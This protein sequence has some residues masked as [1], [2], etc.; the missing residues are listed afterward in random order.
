MNNGIFFGSMGGALGD[1]VPRYVDMSDLN[2]IE[3]SYDWLSGLGAAS[4][5][6]SPGRCP[7]RHRLECV[8]LPPQRTGASQRCPPGTELVKNFNVEQC[9]PRCRTGSV[10]EPERIG[11]RRCVDRFSGRPTSGLGAIDSNTIWMAQAFLNEELSKRR[12]ATVPMDGTLGR[13]TC[14][15]LVAILKDVQKGGKVDPAFADFMKANGALFD[16]PCAQMLPTTVTSSTPP[17]PLP[18]QPASSP[19]ATPPKFELEQC[20]INFGDESD[21]VADVQA[22]L[23]EQLDAEGYEPIPETGQWDGK[24]CGALFFL[25]GRFSP[26]PIPPCPE[27]Q[28]P[29]EC[30]EVVEPRKKSSRALW[31]ALGGLGVLVVAGGAY[32]VSQ[33]G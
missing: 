5:W 21:V 17:I 8:P 13:S 19:P 15:G 10:R 30:P 16:A 32:A 18:K 22:Q 27:Y 1:S 12:L 33:R 28:V 11:G 31:W 3:D 20:F 29:L 25:R 4:P 2:A 23:N 7:P 6:P 14:E 9:L 26:E 24:T